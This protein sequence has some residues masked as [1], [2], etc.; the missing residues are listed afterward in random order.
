MSIAVMAARQ[1]RKQSLKKLSNYL[2]R[3][4]AEI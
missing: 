3:K 1:S 4:T 2:L